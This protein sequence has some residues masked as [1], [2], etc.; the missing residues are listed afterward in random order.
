MLHRFNKI[1]LPISP[2]AVIIVFG[3]Q[4]YYLHLL[5]SRCSFDSFS[6]RDERSRSFLAGGHD[7]TRWQLESIS[8]CIAQLHRV[9]IFR[10]GRSVSPIVCTASG[11]ICQATRL[12]VGCCS[13]QL[14]AGWMHLQ[15]TLVA[16]PIVYLMLGDTWFSAPTAIR[17]TRFCRLK[18]KVS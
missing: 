12:G 7:V 10:F 8:P 2:N 6:E 3:K 18:A 13:T 1:I 9:R 11:S 5:P 16:V 17:A 14:L 4:Y 15:S